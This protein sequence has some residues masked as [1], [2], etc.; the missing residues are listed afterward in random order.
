MVE[1]P[2]LHSHSVQYEG[3]FLPVEIFFHAIAVD[4]F[5]RTLESRYSM[6]VIAK[7]SICTWYLLHEV[8]KISLEQQ[9]EIKRPSLKVD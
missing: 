2:V 7:L 6:L 3:L 1:A 8:D 4:D 9:R 5:Y